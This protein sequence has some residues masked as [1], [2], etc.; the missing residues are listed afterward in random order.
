MTIFLV[1][2]KINKKMTNI[3]N[4]DYKSHTLYDQYFTKI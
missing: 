4:V 2:S 3:H 1:I